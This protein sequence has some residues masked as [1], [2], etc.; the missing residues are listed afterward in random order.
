LYS[1]AQ[2]RDGKEYKMRKPKKK[3]SITYTYWHW[4]EESKKK[5]PVTITA[6]Q[7]NVTEEHIILLNELDHAADLGDRYEQENRDLS[8]E[9]KKSRYE[10][11]PDDCIGDPTENLGTSKTDPSFIFEQ[12]ADKPNPLVEQLLTLMQKLTPQ[13]ID[14]IYDLFGSQRQLTEIANEEDKSVTAIYNRKSKII[15]RLRKLFAEQ[16]IL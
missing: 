2:C 13:Q 3:Q 16:G 4:D 5:L 11:D 10:C 14:L 1:A 7:D 15:A 6:G 8:T 9:N 12:D